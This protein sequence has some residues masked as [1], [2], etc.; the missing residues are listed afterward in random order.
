MVKVYNLTTG[1][2]P[3]YVY[4]DFCASSTVQ[5][6]VA[7]NPQSTFLYTDTALT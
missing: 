7:F 5:N 3:Q 1:K 6:T 2:E 4:K